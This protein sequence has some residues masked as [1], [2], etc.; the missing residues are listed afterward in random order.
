[1]IS[2]NP[3]KLK[4]SHSR[5]WNIQK[6]I[7]F[8]F[9]LKGISIGIS[10][11]LVPLTLNYLDKERYGLWLTLSSIVSWFSLFD[12]GLGNGFRNKFAEAIA[13]KNDDLA[14]TYVSTTFVLLS[15][16]ICC[17]LAVFFVIN[18][19]LD[20]GKILN[21]A[22]ETRH[23][24]SLLAIICFSFFALRFIFNLITTVFLADQKSALADLVGVLGS[25]LSLIIIFLLMHIGERSLLYLGFALSACPVLVLIIACFTAFTG[26]YKK[27]RPSLKFVD[28]KQSKSLMGLGFLFF[29]PQICGLIIFSTSN[30]IIAQI[31]S[32]EEVTV[33]NIAFKYFSVVTLFFNIILA[34]CWSAYTEAFVKQDFIW[35]KNMIKK[36]III[37]AVFCLGSVVMVILAKPVYGL[38]V[39]KSIDIPHSLTISMAFYVGIFNWNSIFAQ[40]N[41]GV[42]KIYIQVWLSLIAGV[43]FI[44]SAIIISKKIGLSGIP[45]AMI[46]SVILGS[47]IQPMQSSKLIYGNAKGI[48]NK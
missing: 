13:V 23:T 20:W 14:K 5:T 12:I 4:S 11:L 47:F 15:I 36:L 44:P 27:Y 17:V 35:L 40:F 37:W 21:T 42:S 25:L 1:M 29:I 30:V 19:F 34:P 9:L 38:W 41:A 43:V 28:F 6:N 39:G 32:P 16:I 22:A 3:L 46:L 33:Y 7:I 26:K 2:L 48:W 31:F 24:L 45:L 10:L 8:S 18:P